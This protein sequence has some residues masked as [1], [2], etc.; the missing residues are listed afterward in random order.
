[1]FRIPV[2]DEAYE[3]KFPELLRR[4]RGHDLALQGPRF[5]ACRPWFYEGLGPEDEL[6]VWRFIEERY[7]LQYEGLIA[8]R[9]EWGAEGLW[10]IP[11]P[12]SVAYGVYLS[13]DRLGMPQGVIA[14][15]RGWHERLDRQDPGEDPES[16]PEESR[17]EGLT[18][19]KAVKA[20]LGADYY[21]EFEPFREIVIANG[22]AVELEVPKFITGLTR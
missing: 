10:G 22:A 19:A 9:F 20:F 16:D 13:P 17:E 11:F 12:G 5:G 2:V 18:A 14:R 8:V 21:V 15:L 4:W 6:V 1:M 7:L 3:P